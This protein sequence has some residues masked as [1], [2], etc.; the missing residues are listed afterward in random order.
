MS[1]PRPSATPLAVQPTETALATFDT[2]LPTPIQVPIPPSPISQAQTGDL[3]MDIASVSSTLPDYDRSDWRAW[4][5]VD[6]DCQDT[7]QEVLVAES[8]VQVTFE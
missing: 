7:R 3:Q 6:G 4:F 5:D 1:T 2:P 8:A